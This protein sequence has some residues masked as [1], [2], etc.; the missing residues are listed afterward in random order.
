MNDQVR[1]WIT[2][3]ESE[4]EEPNGFLSQVRYGLFDQDRGE[5]FIRMLSEIRLPDGDTIDRRFVSIVWFI[6]LMLTWQNERVAASGGNVRE[7]QK[8]T[9]RVTDMVIKLLGVP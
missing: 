7:F 9:G 5:A 2:S 3:L 4:F 6:P 8:L 1:R